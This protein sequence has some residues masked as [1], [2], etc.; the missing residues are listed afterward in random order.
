MVILAEKSYTPE[1]TDEILKLLGGRPDLIKVFRE[2]EMEHKD[3]STFLW[4]TV[5]KYNNLRDQMKQ[6]D[7]SKEAFA[8]KLNEDFSDPEL[9]I[10]AAIITIKNMKAEAATQ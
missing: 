2:F 8:E 1:E 5:R 9:E 7:A 6:V 10:L 4:D 3:N